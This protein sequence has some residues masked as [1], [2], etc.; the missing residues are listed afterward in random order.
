MSDHTKQTSNALGPF[1]AV[2]GL[3]GLVMCSINSTKKGEYA[4][5]Y[6]KNYD[7]SGLTTKCDEVNKFPFNYNVMLQVGEACSQVVLDELI[8]LCQ[9]SNINNTR[10]VDLCNN[11]IVATLEHNP[12]NFK[13]VPGIVISGLVMVLGI[14][15]YCRREAT[16]GSTAQLVASQNS[17]YGQLQDSQTGSQEN[18][19]DQRGYHAG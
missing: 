1:V 4:G 8:K 12:L 2:L 19:D 9:N 5:F 18:Q 7:S 3:V 10:S 17:L 16:Q 13:V 14:C 15:Y 11:T 6:F